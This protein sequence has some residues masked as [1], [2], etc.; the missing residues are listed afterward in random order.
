VEDRLLWL[1]VASPFVAAFNLPLSVE[2]VREG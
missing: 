1:G 2:S